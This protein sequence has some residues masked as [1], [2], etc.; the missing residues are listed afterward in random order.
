MKTNSYRE[1]KAVDD[2]WCSIF[3]PKTI[4][5]LKGFGFDAGGR[6]SD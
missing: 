3:S 2:E 6:L 5:E 1:I 4:L